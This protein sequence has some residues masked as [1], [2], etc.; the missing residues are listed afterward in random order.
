MIFKS[1]EIRWWSTD[2]DILWEF[3]EKLPEKGEGNREPDRTDYYLQS[4]TIN[5]GIKIREGNHEL[6]VKR[7]K[8]EELDFGTMEHWIK[9]ST[10]EERN[11]LNTVDNQLL[12]DWISVKKER[13]KKTFKIINQNEIEYIKEGFPAEGCGAE[14]TVIQVQESKKTIYTV[15]LEAFSSSNRER[16]NLLSLIEQL[17]LDFS[18][19]RNKDSYGYPEF[20][21]RYD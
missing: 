5:T 10:S 8:D 7:A 16:E 11:I 2:K 13:F 4:Y 14:F 19:F 1:S 21:Q 6:K 12:D 17:G 20:L 15:G 9:W 3:Y 18:S